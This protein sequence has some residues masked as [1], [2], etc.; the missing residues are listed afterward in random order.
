MVSV[1]GALCFQLW[2]EWSANKA[3]SIQCFQASPLSYEELS[4]L[5]GWEL[6]L[7]IFLSLTSIQNL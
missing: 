6:M 1:N 5:G 7:S 3:Q 2:R 4:D